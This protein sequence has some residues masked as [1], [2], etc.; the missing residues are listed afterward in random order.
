MSVEPA[1]MTKASTLAA[2][3][4]VMVTTGDVQARHQPIS[5]VFAIG[6]SAGGLFRTASPQEAFE[7]ARRQLQLAAV[8]LGGNAVVHCRFG[9]ESG[10][11]QAFGCSTT[12]FTVHGYGTVVRFV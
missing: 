6:G 11:A 9:Y 3:G 7:A 5:I 1:A 10:A 2:A 8:S 4:S 12:T